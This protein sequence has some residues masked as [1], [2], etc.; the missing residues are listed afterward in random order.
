MS[1]LLHCFHYCG[2]IVSFEIKKCVSSSFVPF[3]DVLAIWAPLRFHMNFRMDFFISAKK[4][5]KKKLHGDFAN[6][7]I[8]SV[9]HLGSI[10]LAIINILI[11]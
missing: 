8:L 9:D 4:K 3:Q 11:Y 2:F 10:I 1:K 7:S 5:K 6:D